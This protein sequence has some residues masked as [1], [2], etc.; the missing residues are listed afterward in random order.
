MKK[1]QPGYAAKEYCTRIGRTAQTDGKLTLFW[2]GSGIELSVRGSELI[3]EME[4]GDEQYDLWID[5][6]ID[7]SFVTRRMLDIGRQ[8]VTVFRGMD[9]NTVKQVK[10]IRDTQA[11][12]K[13]T[14]SYID[15]IN[16]I[17]DGKLEKVPK[18][19]LNFEVIGDSISSGEG[20]IGHR[21][22][23]DWIPYCFWAEGT[24]WNLTAKALDASVSVLSQSGWGL[25]CSF[26]GDPKEAMPLYYDK[27][28]GVLHGEAEVKRGSQTEYLPGK[29]NEVDAV[30]INLGTNDASGLHVYG[31]R[32]AFT[33][34]AVRF[35]GK[36]RHMHP[37]AKI[38]W[39]YGM[40]GHEL[41]SEI[42]EAIDRFNGTGND[43]DPVFYF[44]AEE[45]SYEDL[46]ARQHP[47]PEAHKK[48]AKK[49]SAFLDNILI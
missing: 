24:Y 37:K 42:K 16:I 30:I 25:Y 34:A 28:C 3:L 40:L 23:T 6:I 27:V 2:T 29:E 4:A 26:E 14:C 32:N 5:V 15:I 36:V 7:G 17:Y 18:H 38:I 44:G 9:P 49:L 10:I 11:M 12:P 43:D 21:E 19:R 8:S 48:T 41:E 20:L 46:G 1:E 22:L 13:D 33:E 45:T 47:G 35:L 39:V 31:S